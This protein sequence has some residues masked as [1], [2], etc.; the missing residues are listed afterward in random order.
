MELRGKD[1]ISILST[2]SK[3]FAH[4]TL[5]NIVS[6]YLNGN[7][8]LP[9]LTR[10]QHRLIAGKDLQRFLKVWSTDHLHQNHLGSV[11][12]IQAAGSHSKPIEL[13]IS[14]VWGLRIWISTDVSGWFLAWLKFESSC[15]SVL[16][17]KL[18]NLWKSSSISLFVL[19]YHWLLD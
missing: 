14:W 7:R 19:L 11:L 1:C 17:I 9:F 8:I 10:R 4:P 18:A 3:R 2:K 12:N 13:R 15:S 6:S 16:N 5:E